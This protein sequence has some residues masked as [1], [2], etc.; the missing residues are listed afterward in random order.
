LFGFEARPEQKIRKHAPVDTGLIY[1]AI[2]FALGGGVL[3]GATGVGPPDRGTGRVF[4]GSA[5]AI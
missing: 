2:A 5:A 1:I 4:G 3:K